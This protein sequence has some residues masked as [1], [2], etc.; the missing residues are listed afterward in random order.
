MEEQLAHLLV[1]LS[2]PQP[3]RLQLGYRLWAFPEF[4]GRAAVF[5][6]SHH[7]PTADQ[8]GSRSAWARSACRCRRRR[9]LRVLFAAFSF[10]S[11]ASLTVQVFEWY[12]AGANVLPLFNSRESRLRRDCGKCMLEQFFVVFSVCACLLLNLLQKVGW[13]D[14]CE[15]KV[16]IKVLHNKF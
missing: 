10:C 9:H 3:H 11:A 2:D 6:S 13:I 16:L 12:C 5:L 8:A 1:V 14:V 4:R 7:S 15:M